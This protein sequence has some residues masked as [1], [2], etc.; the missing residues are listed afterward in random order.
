MGVSLEWIRG[1]R[2]IRAYTDEPV[3][4]ATLLQLIDAARWAPSAANGQ[5]W[6]FVLVRHPETIR[7]LGNLADFV[8][9]NG[10][11]RR[12]P[13]II[14][15]CADPRGSYY[16][17]MDCAFAA[18]NILLAAH[19]LGLGSCFV[20]GFDEAGVKE[21]LEIPKHLEVLGLVTLGRPAEDPVPPPRLGLDEIVRRETYSGGRPPSIVR[22]LTNA[23][24]FS[25]A[26]RVLGLHR[27]RARK[28]ARPGAG[29]EAPTAGSAAGKGE[30][31]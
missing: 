10:H 20:G 15:I 17:Q 7:A 8:V 25:L 11:V 30:T 19:A 6:S 16:Y 18:Q 13:A 26:K 22:R 23:G 27:S 28:G 3:E 14:V 1:R 5:P 12:S 31:R 4:E 21:V 29:K 9:F 2:S 24:T